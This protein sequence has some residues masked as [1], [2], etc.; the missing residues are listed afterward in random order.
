MRNDRTVRRAACLAMIQWACV[1]LS[2]KF[3]LM[4]LYQYRWYFPPDFDLSP[5]LSGRRYTFGG[6]YAFAFYLHL[7][8]SPI[9]LALGTFLL[10]SG[11][12]SRW[13]RIH[14]IAG[15]LQ[16]VIVLL[17]VVPSGL[18]M[19]QQAY[20]GWI[21]EYGFICQSLLTAVTLVL[22]A[23]HAARGRIDP[24]RRW[25]T[26]CYLLL[27]SPLLLRAIA[28]ITIVTGTESEWSYRF[29]AWLSWLAPLVLHEFWLARQRKSIGIQS[30]AC[31]PPEI[32]GVAPILP[33]SSL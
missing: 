2:L 24:H 10:A 13:R 15:K 16:L 18:M 23:A 31:P 1:I 4:I 25:A 8:T 5:F 26:R 29:N 27:W 28:G 17:G 7:A 12:R 11:G 14:R 3:F 33:S 9:A 6:S 20:A 32:G 19:S 30:E 21:S 22:A